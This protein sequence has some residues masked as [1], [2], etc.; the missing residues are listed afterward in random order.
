MRSVRSG[1]YVRVCMQSKSKYAGRVAIA[2]NTAYRNYN[3]EPAS[4]YL[5]IEG[6]KRN[7]KIAESQLNVITCE[8]YERIKHKQDDNKVA[9]AEH[10]V[11]PKDELYYVLTGDVNSV[12]GPFALDEAERVAASIKDENPSAHVIILRAIKE[13]K[14]PRRVVDFDNL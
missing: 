9:K 6:V 4:W 10:V 7:V 3:W 11:K 14:N 13:A 12:D 1:N 8:D 5:I 2:K